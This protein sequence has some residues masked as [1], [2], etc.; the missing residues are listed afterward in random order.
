M[1]NI[2]I[3]RIPILVAIALFAGCS[4]S[5]KTSSASNAESNMKALDKVRVETKE[6]SKAIQDYAHA[7]RVEYANAMKLM[8]ADAKR[9]VDQIE[10]RIKKSSDEVRLKAEPK[11][12]ELRKKIS[13]LEAQL[14]TVGDAS[15]STWS[16]VKGGISS[17]YE[18][19]KTGL[20]DARQWVSDVIE[21]KKTP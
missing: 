20:N 6:T 18:S 12:V 4:P 10:S 9:D 21:P 17:A 13:N 3:I 7:Q 15:E 14:E 2:Q 11:I 19:T 1:K 5:P 8:I 16:S